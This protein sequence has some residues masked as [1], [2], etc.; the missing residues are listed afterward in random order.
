MFQLT[1]RVTLT[2]A[3]LAYLSDGDPGTERVYA[4]GYVEEIAEATGI[5]TSGTLYRVRWYASRRQG[6]RTIFRESE[7]VPVPARDVTRSYLT[8]D[9]TDWRTG[10]RRTVQDDTFSTPSGPIDEQ[11]E[12]ERRALLLAAEHAPVPLDD[13]HAFGWDGIHDDETAGS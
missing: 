12:V 13:A 4:L 1:D 3:M 11:G 7:L 2:P 6:F 8:A 9:G 10:L 5:P